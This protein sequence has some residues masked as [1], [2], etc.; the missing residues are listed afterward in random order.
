MFLFIEFHFKILDCLHHSEIQPW[1]CVFMGIAWVILSWLNC[2][3]FVCVPL[4]TLN[5]PM[6]LMN[7]LSCSL[8]CP[9]SYHPGS[10][11][12]VG[13]GWCILSWSVILFVFVEWDLGML[14]SFVDCGSDVAIAERPW[15][16]IWCKWDEVR[17]TQG[18]GLACR[19]WVMW[20][21][22]QPLFCFLDV[23]HSE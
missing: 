21:H 7:D 18:A 17:W 15:G 16:W 2:L 11:G 10:I 19:M 8:S 5:S 4:N 1:V 6:K 13:L 12:L 14:I 22:L 20:P 23:S 9:E 3:F